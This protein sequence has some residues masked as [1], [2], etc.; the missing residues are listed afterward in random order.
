[1]QGGR[2]SVVVGLCVAALLAPATAAADSVVFIKGG[3]V[4]LL[5]EGGTVRLTTDGGYESP[6]MADDGTI[7]V[8]RKTGEDPDRPEA[9]RV[10]RMDTSGRLLN[11][12]TVAVPVDNSNYVGPSGAQV[13]PDGRLVAFHYFNRGAVSRPEMPRVAIAPTDRDL[14]DLGDIFSQGYYLNPTWI[15]SSTIVLFGTPGFIPNVQTY[16][17]GSEGIADWFDAP[18]VGHLGGGELSADGTR[19]AATVDGG[20][21]L[22]LF[23]VPGPP[24]A[25]PQ[26]TCRFSGTEGQFQRPR[27]SPD[28]RE[29]VWES[30]DG[31]HVAAVPAIDDCP[32]IREGLVAPGGSD[33]DYGPADLPAGP[34]AESGP[35]GG[36][37]IQRY[38]RAVA[39]KVICASACSLNVKL[40]KAGR[41]VSKAAKRL[42]KSG[43][44][45]VVL[46]KRGRKGKATLVITLDGRT[47]RKGVVL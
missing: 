27:W 29:L 25:A 35:A 2:S 21:A 22:Q 6:S 9:R 32:N 10:H 45:R 46:P 30:P 24:P 43:M 33:P 16:T 34:E 31:L 41:T 13:S 36:P 28:G 42:A 26:P 17:L 14:N 37:Q 15:G 3:D 7:V 20:S 38:A 11:P 40:V 23:S 19:F 5:G 1:M 4:H 47:Q 8:I 44:A 12:P 39:V 18:G